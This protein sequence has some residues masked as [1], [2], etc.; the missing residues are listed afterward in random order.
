MVFLVI[1]M[2]LMLKYP[3]PLMLIRNNISDQ[4][5][6]RT[7]LSWAWTGDRRTGK[8]GWAVED[9]H[10]IIRAVLLFLEQCWHGSSLEQSLNTGRKETSQLISLAHREPRPI[11]FLIFSLLSVLTPSKLRNSVPAGIK[12]MTSQPW[13]PDH[14]HCHWNSSL[15]NKFVICH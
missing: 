14:R 15:W 9:E 10:Y 8:A 4:S 11:L 2:S 7:S 5:K 3:Q 1:P 13:P 6:V 12:P